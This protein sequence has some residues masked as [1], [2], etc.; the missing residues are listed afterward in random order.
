MHLYFVI[1]SFISYNSSPK[2]FFHIPFSFKFIWEYKAAFSWKTFSPHLWSNSLK[3]CPLLA[4]SLTLLFSLGSL[5][6]L[7]WRA[8]LTCG[9]DS[10]ESACNVGDLGRSLSLKIPWRREW[11]PSLVFLPGESHWQWSLVG[12]SP[13]DGK[14]WATICTFTFSLIFQQGRSCW[15]LLKETLTFPPLYWCNFEKV[16]WSPDDF[17]WDPVM[18][19]L[20][21]QLPL[22]FDPYVPVCILDGFVK[23]GKK[24][25]PAWA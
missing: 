2:Y 24:F 21:A 16:G 15:A 9:S 10:E 8:L 12:Y 23:I 19:L 7:Y 22:L 25:Q 1:F 5:S 20:P 18:E 14:D 3:A 13:W 11:Q 6:D 17:G 4:F